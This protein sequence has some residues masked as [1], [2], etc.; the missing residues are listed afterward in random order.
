[1]N[2][3]GNILFTILEFIIAIGLLAFLHE[4]GHFLVARLFK[5]EVEEFG[6]G[7]PPRAVKLFTWGGTEFT[8]NWIPFG[9]FVRPKGEN[10]PEIPG[11]LAAANPWKRLAMLFGGSTMNLAT[12]VLIFSIVVS[13]LGIADVTKVKVS[14]VS[15]G[16]PAQT[17]GLIPG[18]IFLQVNGES[19]DSYEKLQNIS[20]QNI[21]IEISLLIQR[22]EQT[23]ETKLTPRKDPPKGQKA[24]G[25][26]LGNPTKSIS[27][28][29]SIPYGFQLTGQIITQMVQLPGKLIKG[30]VSPEESRVVGPVGMYSIFEQAREMDIESTA[31]PTPAS[32]AVNT[33]WLLGVIST[34][35]GF[36][37]LLPI[38]A[39]D[40]GRI[41]FV[42]PEIFLRRRVPA[43]YENL[44]HTIGFALLILVMVYVTM[45]DIF[46][47]IVLP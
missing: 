46:N 21:G 47:P 12:G 44:I 1:M 24:M 15:E 8:L 41:I 39:L 23:I 6:F 11:G 10:D 28:G 25:L 13:R 32:P 5:I 27:V 3:S 18:D 20:Q 38:P 42:L 40:G 37:N 43:K 45:Q 7:F 14:A 19:I 30:Q 26:T 34:A 22:G 31:S 33:L 4:L 2:L 17:A 16:S 36:T 9:A 29:E 35:L